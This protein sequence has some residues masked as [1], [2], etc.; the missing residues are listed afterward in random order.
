MTGGSVLRRKRSGS[1]RAVPGVLLALAAA[2]PLGLAACASGAMGAD[3]NVEIG[4]SSLHLS[5]PTYDRHGAISFNVDNRSGQ[6]RDLLVVRFNHMTA[7]PLT[8]TG[9]VD[10]NRLSLAD[11]IDV[12]AP[13]RYHFLSPDLTPG[14]YLFVSMAVPRVQTGAPIVGNQRYVA[15]VTGVGPYQPG[16]AERFV[17]T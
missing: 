5:Q 8:S 10:V 6:Y 11:Q 13:G 17:V 14:T 16:M 3:V 9:T 15:D 7:L 2:C 4:P 1:L 12:L